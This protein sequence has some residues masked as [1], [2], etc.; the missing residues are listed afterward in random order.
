MCIVLMGFIGTSV[1]VSTEDCKVCIYPRP[2][3]M[4][5]SVTVSTARC[6]HSQMGLMGTYVKSCTE[7]EQYVCWP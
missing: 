4:R 2:N 6:V 3:F 1:K 7:W 5:T